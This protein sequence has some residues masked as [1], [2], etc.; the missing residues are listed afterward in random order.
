MPDLRNFGVRVQPVLVVVMVYIPSLGC[1][2]VLW[3]IVLKKFFSKR[4]SGIVGRLY[5]HISLLPQFM[6]AK[7][8][9]IQ[10]RFKF[11]HCL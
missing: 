9:A 5:S 6:F 3:C 2:L 10:L 4:Q 1:L 11:T 8:F 7:L